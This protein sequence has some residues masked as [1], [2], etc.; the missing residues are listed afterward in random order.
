LSPPLTG[1]IAVSLDSGGHLEFGVF[2]PPQEDAATRRNLARW[3]EPAAPISDHDEE[4]VVSSLV[5]VLRDP[6]PGLISASSTDRYFPSPVSIDGRRLHLHPLERLA[7][8]S[9]Q[10]EISAVAER[11]PD[12]ITRTNQPA[13]GDRLPRVS[14]QARVRSTEI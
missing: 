9:N 5:E 12:S 11:Q 7:E 14:L 10:I 6:V 2:R 4:E 13:C 8:L 3:D 1:K